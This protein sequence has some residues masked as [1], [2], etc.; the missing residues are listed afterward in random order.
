M[1]RLL[2]PYVCLI[3]SITAAA[4]ADD[5]KP[6]DPAHA[7]AT[8]GGEGYAPF[9]IRR[10]GPSAIVAGDSIF[11]AFQ[12]SLGQPVVMM[13]DRPSGQWDG[14]FTASKN[15]LGKD[16]HGSPAM[17]IDANGYFHLFFG[18]HS[19]NAL[20]YVRSRK[21]WDISE[22]EEQPQFAERATYPEA[23]RLA[24]GQITLA[25][26]AGKHPDPWVTHTSFDNGRTWQPQQRLIEMRLDPERPKACAYA[27]FFPG[28]DGR[29]VHCVFNYKEDNHTRWLPQYSK[30][31]A[32]IHRF[33]IYYMRRDE[34]G[35]WRNAK[36]EVLSLPVTKTIA[37]AKCV[38]Y[39]TRDA[40]CYPGQYATDVDDNPYFVF[41]TGAMNWNRGGP[42]NVFLGD[43]PAINADPRTVTP[44]AEYFTTLRREQWQLNE[45]MPNSW[46]DDIRQFMS[47][48]GEA[49]HRYAE[50][51]IGLDYDNT[52]FISF[53]PNARPTAIFLTSS[54]TGPATRRGG[55]AR[56]P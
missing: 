42:D 52:W 26:R 25:Y 33:N 37:D 20:R 7:F 29:T 39:E 18:S 34:S 17:T 8:I 21:A 6:F 32:P 27:R 30:L 44:F 54:V 35:T 31:H 10:S 53:D 22:W 46:P 14:P 36:G 3:L 49:A 13:F 55:P 2:I 24:G 23:F 41:R 43:I 51:G 1:P 12:N 38:V 48:P 45:T 28:R 5:A 56:L 9:Y 4:A 11:C 16:M 50:T 19:K 47:G 15:G 40:Y